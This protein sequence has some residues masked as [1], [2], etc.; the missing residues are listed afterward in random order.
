MQWIKSLF[1]LLF[2]TASAPAQSTDGIYSLVERR[3]PNHVDHFGFVIDKSNLTGTEGYDQF[4]VSSAP[5]GSILVKG[6]SI[7]ALSSGYPR[8]DRRLSCRGRLLDC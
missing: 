6:N 2:F 3:L 1:C 5:N 8:L 4:V 7:S